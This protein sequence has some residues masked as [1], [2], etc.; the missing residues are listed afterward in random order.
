MKIKKILAVACACLIGMT[1]VGIAEVSDVISDDFAAITAN[2]EDLT[3]GF[4]QYSVNNDGTVNIKGYTGFA[5]TLNIPSKIDGRTVTAIG[6]YA[7]E[8]NTNFD[9]VVIPST[10]TSINRGAFYGSGLTS[11][12]IPSSVT[13]IGY[14]AFR[15]TGLKSITIPSTVKSWGTYSY[16]EGSRAFYDCDQLTTVVFNAESI[17]QNTFY[18]CDKLKTVTSS[19]KYIGAS[20][21]EYCGNLSTFTNK[22]DVLEIDANAFKYCT[23]LTSFDMGNKL[24]YIGYD[25]F[26]ETGLKSI[27][28]PS[29]VKS[30]GT[31]SYY[32][33]SRAFYDCDQLTTVVFNAESI[34]QNTFYDCDKL[35]TV[36]SSAKYIGASAFEYC[37][38]L[39][40]FTNKNDVLEIDA[41]A[42][43][44]CTSLTS[45]DMGNK[46]TYIGY[47]AFRETGLKSITIPSTVK[48]WGTYS[49]YEGSRAFYDCK[50]LNTIYFGYNTM[51]DNI[52]NI[53]GVTFY[54]YPGSDAL[55]YAKDKAIPYKQRTAVASTAIKLNKTSL[56]M[57]E[58]YKYYL[59]AV[60]TPSNSTDDITW[61]SGDTNIATVNSAGVVT[62]KKAGLVSIK[63]TTRSGKTAVCNITVKQACEVGYNSGTVTKKAT[64]D[65]TGLKEYTCAC[66]AIYNEPTDK[67]GHS[68]TSKVVAPTYAAQGYTKHTCSRCGNVYKD[69]YKAKK[70]VKKLTAKTTYTCT[71]NAVRINWNKLSGVTGYKIFRYDD[72]KKKWVAV[73]AIYNP[74]TTN[75]KISGLKSG[76]VYKFR[77]KAF[78][79]ENGKF[80]FGESCS[81]ISTATRPNTTTVTKANKTSTA[82]RLFWKKT[83]CSGYRILRYDSAKKKWVRVTAVGS[84]ATTQYK[85]SGL[86]KNTTYKFK[87]QPYVKVGSKV[88]DGAA[89]AVFTVKTTK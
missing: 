13:Y 69:N 27:T 50:K 44:Y 16:Y 3:S 80:Y 28:I 83:T 62:A 46:L 10:V 14:D 12:T 85:I 45:F 23:S 51:P 84:S 34:I 22:N 40:T 17:I 8:N 4:W 76:K 63:A 25:A 70:T 67:L 72:A 53:S 68:Y 64:C 43:K 37:G 52:T 41:N 32:E 24:T 7:F 89:S 1:A 5:D 61:V 77:V 86:K 57:E 81:T 65:T 38:N 2:A 87:V 48:S 39:S 47:D 59:D 30:W 75:Y 11:V 55:Q 71:T 42:F 15:E 36:T 54:C 31:Y 49:Y 79:K 33:G 82:V 18:D 73:K 29:T 6:D 35:K 74:N 78:V 58:G 56:T 26:R 19:A 21:F 60:M 66:K 9:S 88:I 20:A